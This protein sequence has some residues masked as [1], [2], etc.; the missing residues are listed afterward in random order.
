MTDTTDGAPGT[1]ADAGRP[2]RLAVLGSPIAHSKSPALH[3]AAYLLYLHRERLRS[4]G[5]ATAVDPDVF[6]DTSSYGVH[7]VDAV[8][9]EVGV[10]RL[11]HGSDRP[12]IPAAELPLGPA[13]ERALRER[14]PSRLL[15][16]A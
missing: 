8:L 6:L 10:D 4:R 16:T 2:R 5:G 11:V 15:G 13:V 12:V 1:T 3:R 7:A 14:N 9:R